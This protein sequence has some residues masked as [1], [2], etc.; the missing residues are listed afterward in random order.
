MLEKKKKKKHAVTAAMA[1]ARRV[2]SLCLGMTRSNGGRR[3]MTMDGRK[4]GTSRNGWN[5][6]I[7]VCYINSA[8][9]SQRTGEARGDKLTVEAPRG[10]RSTSCGVIMGDY[11]DNLVILSPVSRRGYCGAQ[12]DHIDGC[13]NKGTQ[14]NAHQA[15]H[16]SSHTCNP[17]GGAGVVPW[18]SGG[19]SLVRRC[20]GPDDG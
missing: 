7:L 6:A 18:W 14:K 8:L 13:D 9:I 10:A 3:G 11:E 12:K 16:S 15:E 2:M 1:R 17:C 20:S 19:A 5:V 4:P